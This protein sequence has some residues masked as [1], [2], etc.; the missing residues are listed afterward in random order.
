MYLLGESAGLIL[1]CDEVE[2]VPDSWQRDQEDR[3][4]R[5]GDGNH[6]MARGEQQLLRYLEVK[7]TWEFKE[8]PHG[9]A[10]VLH[11]SNTD[12]ISPSQPNPD[13]LPPTLLRNIRLHFLMS[14]IRWKGA[15]ELVA[16]VL[17]V[18]PLSIFLANKTKT[19]LIVC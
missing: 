11:G 17:A 14:H 4:H 1:C 12:L 7:T 16:K 5:G 9:K 6:Q 8:E 3:A 13:T 2:D 18:A 15:L 19:V 10:I